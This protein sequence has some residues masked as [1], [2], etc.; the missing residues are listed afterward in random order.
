MLATRIREGEQNMISEGR[1]NVMHGIAALS[2]VGIL[3][4]ADPS[5]AADPPTLR[6]GYGSAAEEQL[7]L[8]LAKPELGKNYGKTYKLESSRF[9]SST[10]RSQAF[11]ANAID[12]ASSGTVGILFAAAEGVTGKVIASLARESPRGF[13]TSYYVKADSPIKSVPDAK[14]KIVGINGFATDGQLWLRTAMQRHN[15][16]DS[17]VTITPVPF[18]AMAEAL[19]AGKVDVGEFPQPFAD[20]LEKE[21]KVRKLFDSQY[22]M[23]FEQ[24]LILLLGKDAFL[25]QNATAIRGLLEDLQAST[26]FYLERTRE[27]RQI[28][29][30]AKTVRLSPDVYLNMKDYYRDPTLRPDAAALQRVQDIMIKTDFTKKR[31][32][33]AAMIDASYLPK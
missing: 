16:S 27:A 31:A 8:L 29:L 10:Q 3:C 24:E 23:P 6:L 15:L 22:G 4:V 1:R 5:S 13:A 30:D 18:P 25:K 21:M 28:I 12:L 14:G 17:D 2:F 7:Y 11:E 9:Q 32:D 19:N 33:I 20:M 26:R